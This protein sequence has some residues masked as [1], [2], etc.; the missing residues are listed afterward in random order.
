MK[1]GRI[2]AAFKEIDRMCG[3]GGLPFRT[4]SRLYSLRNRMKPLIEAQ[5]DEEMRIVNELADV[6]EKG[7]LSFHEEGGKSVMNTLFNKIQQTEV[8]W[9]EKP[10]EIA[11]DEKLGLSGN[12]LSA[13]EGFV[14]IKED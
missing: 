1:Q 8:D 14:V 11:Y 5:Y 12:S 3:I 2:T 9:D 7:T 6:D 10:E 4:I 13:L